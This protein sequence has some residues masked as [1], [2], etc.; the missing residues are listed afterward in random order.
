MK[1]CRVLTQEEIG[2]LMETLSLRDQILMLTGLT[3]GTRISEAL[4]LTFDA[5]Q[6][7]YLAIHSTKGGE[8]IAFPIPLVYQEKIAALQKWYESQ[9]VEVT[10]ATPLFLSQKGYYTGKP[11]TRQA[12]SQTIR[13]ICR[14][15]GIDGKVNSHSFRKCFVT[16]IYRATGN[17]LAQTKVYSRHKSLS[18]LDYY[19]HTAKDTSLVKE[20]NWGCGQPRS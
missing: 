11:M 18:N 14:R 7:E 13:K 3:F 6:G 12:A 5:V 16:A 15:L 9:G 4:A 1:G 10:Q 19:I 20:L 8:N 17:D 2:A